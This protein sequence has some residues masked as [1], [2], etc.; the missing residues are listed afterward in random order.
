MKNIPLFGEKMILAKASIDKIIRKAGA[1]RVSS[2]AAIR[3]AEILEEEGIEIAKEAVELAG[4]VKRK[5]V[6]RED[7][8]LVLKQ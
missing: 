2:E 8:R 4:H 1:H 7:I 3:L 6:K 5:T